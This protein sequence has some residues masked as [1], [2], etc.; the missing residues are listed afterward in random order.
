MGRTRTAFFK[1]K[2]DDREL[3]MH[4][5]KIGKTMLSIDKMKVQLE[6]WKLAQEKNL[7]AQRAVNVALREGKIDMQQA[8]AE[9]LELQTKYK[10]LTANI[11]KTTW[12]IEQQTVQLK[13]LQSVEEM[14]DSKAKARASRYSPFI[15][16][17]TKIGIVAFAL[18]KAFNALE[19]GAISVDLKNTLGSQLANF[20]QQMT[21]ARKSTAGMVSDLNLMKSAALMSSFRIPMENWAD[22]LGLISKMAIRTGQDVGYLMN[23]YATGI[24]RL[25]PRILDNL[26]IQVSLSES[27]GVY[28]AQ[29][30]KTADKLSDVEQRQAVINEVTRQSEKL[31]EGIDLEASVATPLKQAQAALQNL[32]DSLFSGLVQALYAVVDVWKGFGA[33]I[34]GTYAEYRATKELTTALREAV[35]EK[36]RLNSLGKD[37]TFVQRR[38]D[39]LNHEQDVIK[40]FPELWKAMGADWR[41]QMDQMLGSGINMAGF[42]LKKNLADL[43]ILERQRY[44]TLSAQA[45]LFQWMVGLKETEAKLTK[46]I[47]DNTEISKLEKAAALTELKKRIAADYADLVLRAKFD[48][49]EEIEDF[50][51]GT[52]WLERWRSLFENIRKEQAGGV[53]AAVEFNAELEA[54]IGFAKELELTLKLRLARLN[55]ANVEEQRLIEIQAERA[56]IQ[57]NIQDLLREGEEKGNQAIKERLDLENRN[58]DI[59]AEDEFQ[60]HKL[61]RLRKE[62][63]EVYG[64]RHAEYV[65]MTKQQMLIE[66]RKLGGLQREKKERAELFKLTQAQIAAVI[67]G[68]SKSEAELES[69][70]AK[71][72]DVLAR[73]DE[74]G[75]S[76]PRGGGGYGRKKKENDF[77]DKLWS[78]LRNQVRHMGQDILGLELQRPIFNISEAA[79]SIADKSMQPMMWEALRY[80]QEMVQDD[81]QM[82]TVFGDTLLGL[83]LDPKAAKK[84]EGKLDEFMLV[85][86]KSF[87][88]MKNKFGDVFN[89]EMTPFWSLF[90]ETKFKEAA[91]EYEKVRDNLLARFGVDINVAMPEMYQFYLQWADIRD[92]LHEAGTE[93]AALGNAFTNIGDRAGKFNL[94]G[95]EGVKRFKMLGSA[96]TE[97]GKALEAEGGAANAVAAGVKLLGTVAQ[98]FI[99][100]RKDIAK[101]EALMEGAAAWASWAKGDYAAS[102]AH[103]IAAGMYAAIGGGLIKLPSGKQGDKNSS[104]KTAAA[105]KGGDLHVHVYGPI[106]Q[107]EAE[108]GALINHALQQARSEGRI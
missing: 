88:G 60:M 79:Y 4:G 67:A 105:G 63:S 81:E 82:R 77:F 32:V 91:A 87:S 73:L 19:Q 56:Q 14:E 108:R 31:V 106:L 57:K 44:E 100:D 93:M 65:G 90:T 52:D 70:I 61:I 50:M 28:A 1:V 51:E 9:T 34:D 36:T 27:Y 35:A 45:T 43:D 101:I 94:I 96:A 49:A 24:S 102:A 39:W 95:D 38:I 5:L 76:V 16:V 10:M 84:A 17:A 13:K 97:F 55:G 103:M 92:V 83:S 98:S 104:D 64:K 15:G 107:S 12:A 40:Q 21:K 26:G 30:G 66:Y 99:K 46:E 53:K 25:S 85:V 7:A 59:L 3:E 42:K 74:L 22:T 72:K 75:K 23:S 86:A 47:N 80:F 69:R 48:T 2:V 62:E 33:V 71:I 37:T 11:N 89:K 18:K 29:L 58:L 20:D 41:L 6:L 54:S 68:D 8:V 78:N